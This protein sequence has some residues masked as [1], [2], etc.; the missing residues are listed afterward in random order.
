MGTPRSPRLTGVSIFLLAGLILLVSCAGVKPTQ[1]IYLPP[2]SEVQPELQST[3]FNPTPYLLYTPLPIPSTPAQVCTDGL[4]FIEDITIPDG[5][6]LQPGTKVDKQWRVENNGTC[7]WDSRYSLHLTSGD[8]LTGSSEQA[9]Y[10]ARAGTQAVIQVAFTTPGQA[11]T[12]K[13]VWQAVSPQGQPFG[14]PISLLII[15]QP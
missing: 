6:N 4:L 15:I 2:T 11:G 8:N 1:P 14:D 9:L 10:P 13:S 12:Y 7:N 5:I 3:S